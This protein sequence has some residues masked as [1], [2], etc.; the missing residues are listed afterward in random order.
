LG[1]VRR[2]FGE[3]TVI[4]EEGILFESIFLAFPELIL[5]GLQLLEAYDLIALY[6]G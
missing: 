3:R 1:V 4:P 2:L 5:H 6:A